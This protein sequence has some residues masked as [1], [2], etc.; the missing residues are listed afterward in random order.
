M[1]DLKAAGINPILAG[2]FDAS[3]PAGSV[4]TAGNI[5]G[6]AVEGAQKASVTALQVQNAR[7]TQFQA[8]L[9]EPKALIARGITTGLKT[10]KSKVKTF[11]LPSN[12]ITGK[13]V[14]IQNNSTRPWWDPAGGYF[15]KRGSIYEQNRTHNQAGLR[16]V[17]A[18]AK[19]HP[20]AKK[21]ELT[22]IY[23][24]AVAKSKSRNKRN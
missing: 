8:D 17:F 15:D 20:K 14:Q 3:S 21:A 19:T 2:K 9:L 16:A 24:D 1:A 7:Y 12:P 4:L 11:P 18:Y 23:D 5:G 10:A 22:K 13:G 6:A